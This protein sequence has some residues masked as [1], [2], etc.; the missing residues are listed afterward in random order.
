MASLLVEKQVGGLKLIGCSLAGEETVIGLPELNVCFDIGRAPREVLS[1]DNVCISHGHIDHASGVPYYFAQREFIGIAPGRVIVH[2]ELA[3]A[4]QALMAVWAEIDGH[5]SPGTVLGV[6]PG[7]DVSVRR[8]LLIRP[9]G[10]NHGRSA[11]GF[12]VIE[13][14]HKLKPEFADRTG[15][16]LVALKQQGVQIE[17]HIE[18]PLVAYCG[19]TA[20][21]EFLDLDWVR[22]AG[23][24]LLECTFFDPEHVVRA[25]AGRHI[26]V[27]DLRDALPRLRNPHIVLTHVTRRTDLGSAKRALEALTEPA[28]HPRLSFLMDRARRPR[29]PSPPDRSPQ[30]VERL[31]TSS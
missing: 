25:R 22:N 28:D 13:Q 5:H 30:P 20:A 26:H 12:S 31:E 27:R 10:V 4:F 21:G 19:D 1:I 29:G 24:L 7:E 6:E 15:P 2:R 18:V 16:Q 3:Q 9:F 23:V 11:L 17:H 8:D 14:R